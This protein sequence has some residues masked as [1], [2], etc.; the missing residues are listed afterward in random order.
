MPIKVCHILDNLRPGVGV[1]QVA[2]DLMTDPNIEPIGL[3]I[4]S[5]TIDHRFGQAGIKLIHT[6]KTMEMISQLRK[7]RNLGFRTIHVHSRKAVVPLIIANLMGYR[8]VRTQHFGT[9]SKADKQSSWPSNFAR[10]LR[11]L[12]TLKSYWITHWAAIS[13]TSKT[14]IQ[15]RWGISD[16]RIS[17]IYNGIDLENYCTPTAQ[18][19][20]EL[21]SQLNLPDYSVVFVSIGSLLQRKRHDLT[22]SAFASIPEAYPNAR[23]VIAGDGSER[24]NLE[25]QIDKLNLNSHVHLLGLRQDVPDILAASD[26]LVHSAV[27][28]AFGLVIA[29]GMAT[30][31]P[32][33][34]FDG[35][36]PSELVKQNETGIVVPDRQ[37]EAFTEAMRKMLHS[38]SGRVELGQAGRQAAESM[39][40]LSAVRARYK[41]LYAQ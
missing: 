31:L 10:T 19:R 30:G 11:N 37:I 6:N 20:A 39:F 41:T 25:T 17:I 4:G 2:F 8:V 16:K 35:F 28:E 40:D 3:Y 7:L 22:V 9:L 34:V 32:A 12:F 36:G 5:D 24:Q 33:I 23:L 26:V 13:K 15:N 21:R 1:T 29:E 27:D 14:Y 38:A 18:R